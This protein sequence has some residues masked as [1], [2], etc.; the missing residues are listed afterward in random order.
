M[1]LI[2]GFFVAPFVGSAALFQKAADGGAT[3]VAAPL[4]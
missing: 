4:S 1:I 2:P 3:N